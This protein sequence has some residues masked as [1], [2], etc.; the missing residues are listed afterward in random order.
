MVRTFIAIEIPAIIRSTITDLQNTLKKDPARIGWVKVD[1]IHITL[2]F[3]GDVERS[4]IEIISQAVTQACKIF[5]PF[6]VR[7]AGV[8]AFPNMH[9]PRVIWVG[10]TSENESLVRL[11]MSIQTALEPLGF[12][13]EK[14]SFKAHLTIGRVKD[15]NYIE[16]VMHRLNGYSSFD[17]GSFE[18]KQIIVMQSE[19]RSTG[20][21]YTPLF[22][23]ELK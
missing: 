23:A 5:N 14:Q 4:K 2:K 10:A 9:R 22:V 6:S 15:T 1:N 13:R 7:V 21:V 18:V 20:S 8:G 3:L 11:A 17:G 12:P 16:R 19:L